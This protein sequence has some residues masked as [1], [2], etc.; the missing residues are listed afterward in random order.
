[1]FRNISPNEGAFLGLRVQKAN[2]TPAIGAWAA[3]WLPDGRRLVGQADGGSGHSGKRSPD[4]H[5]GL[6][7]G[8]ADQKLRVEIRWR[9]NAGIETHELWLKPGWHTIHVGGQS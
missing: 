7:R 5:F 2:G 4:I 6:G 8:T 1:L 9:S 3:V